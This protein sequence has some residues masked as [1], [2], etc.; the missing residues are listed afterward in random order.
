MI[1]PIKASPGRFSG[2]QLLRSLQNETHS[3]PTETPRVEYGKITAVDEETS[4]VRVALASRNGWSPEI[5]QF[6][7]LMT[8]LSEIYLKWGALRPG[9][10]IRLWYKGRE[11]PRSGTVEVIGEETDL[12]FLKKEKKTNIL[13]TGPYKLITGGLLG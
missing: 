4:Q 8:P 7:P 12:D 11:N 9:L 6:L 5:P 10:A 13:D 1:G 3:V 2:T